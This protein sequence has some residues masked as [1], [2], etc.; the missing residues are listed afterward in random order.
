[1]IR[2][3]N[4]I[5]SC[6]PCSRLAWLTDRTG[7]LKFG[8]RILQNIGQKSEVATACT[9]PPNRRSDY[10]VEDRPQTEKYGK[11]PSELGLYNCNTPVKILADTG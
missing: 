7:R 9:S 8:N 10:P 2:K 1:M 5:Q 6:L 3:S 4:I 11:A